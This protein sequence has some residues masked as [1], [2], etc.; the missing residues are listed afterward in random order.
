VKNGIVVVT[1]AA[2]VVA[3]CSSGPAPFKPAR[4]V[5]PPGTAHVTIDDRYA[6]TNGAVQCAAVGSLT[7]IKAGDENS[8]ETVMVSEAKKLTVEFVRIRNLNGFT[9][10][11]NRGLEGDAA[12]AMTRSTYHVTGTALGFNPKSIK[13]TTQPFTIEVAC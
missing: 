3:A 8:G 1:A 6:D 11:Y 13:P 4:G 12:V 7:T 2:L 5:L 9:G 10:D